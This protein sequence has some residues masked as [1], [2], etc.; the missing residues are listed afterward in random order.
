MKNKQQAFLDFYKEC[1]KNSKKMP[2]D[3]LCRNLGRRID[4]VKP[5]KQDI[6]KLDREDLSASYWGSGLAYWDLN[7]CH[8][9][10]P[11]RQT[12]VLLLAC[13]NEEY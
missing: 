11:L 12:L 4:P 5:T 9:F 2:N 8:K 6:I 7:K 3:G 1:M 10:T 13:I